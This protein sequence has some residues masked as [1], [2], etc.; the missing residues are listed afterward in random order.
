MQKEKNVVVGRN[1]FDREHTT[2]HPRF[3]PSGED[4]GIYR[5]ET[6]APR[7]RP[8]GMSQGAR[9]LLNNGNNKIPDQVRDDNRRRN[10]GFTLIELL[11]VVLIIGILAAVAVPQYQ[12]AVEKSKA[13][14]GLTLIKSIQEAQKAYQLAN[15]TYASTFDELS[16]D[17]P[18]TGSDKAHPGNQITDTRSNSDWS[19]QLET[20]PGGSNLFA[21]R[22]KGP[23]KG[24]GFIAFGSTGIFCT[25]QHASVGK[26]TIIFGKNPGDYCEKIL[27]AKFNRDSGYHRLYDLSY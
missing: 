12:K 1:M 18:F 14:Q 22:L 11:V 7:Q 2:F 24:A 5:N 10:S 20:K 19:I 27:G 15:G 17:I 4:S 23:Y 16:I 21:L 9:S 26:G 8:S 13:M 25:E 3:R 6:T